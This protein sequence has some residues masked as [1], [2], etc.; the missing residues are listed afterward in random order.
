MVMSI[1]YLFRY[2]PSSILFVVRGGVPKNPAEC[3]PSFLVLYAPFRVLYARF[4]TIVRILKGTLPSTCV[5]YLW[6]HGT[7]LFFVRTV[8]FFTRTIP[9]FS[10]AWSFVRIVFCT[11]SSCFCTHHF[12]YAQ[13]FVKTVRFP[14][15]CLEVEEPGAYLD[16]TEGEGSCKPAVGPSPSTLGSRQW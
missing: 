11:H 7:V 8:S 4:P 10:Y 5:T 2:N 12:L 9:F 15:P 1:W 6:T 16:D 14:S 3:P 13:F